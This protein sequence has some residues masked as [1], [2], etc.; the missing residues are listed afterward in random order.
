MKQTINFITPAVT[1]LLPDGSVDLASAGSLYNRLIEGGMDGILILGSIGE[2]FG[3]PMEAKKA[4]VENAVKAV[5]HRVE[6][7]VGTTSMLF[8]EIVEFSNFALDAGADAVMVIPPFYFHFTDESV[9]AYFDELAQKIHGRMYLYNF[10]DRTGY[11]I[12]PAV[13]CELAKK[14]E[15]IVGIKDTIAGVDH[16]RQLVKAVKQI[17][18]EF[19]VYSGFD[20]NF[21]HN[22]LCGG[23]GCIAGLSNLYPTLTSSW[24]SAAREGDWAKVQEIQQD[25]DRLMDIYAVG[26]PFVPFIKEAM[27]LKGIISHAAATRPMP[28]ATEEQKAQLLAVMDRYEKSL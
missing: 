27:A 11:E 4:L 8:D 16:T 5:D 15:N 3:I 9:F 18:P 12:S 24:A 17:R 2:F 19:L 6:L 13:V 22:V 21:A 7:I 1:P 10:P 26:K 20:D 25:I 14:H 28:A 23:N